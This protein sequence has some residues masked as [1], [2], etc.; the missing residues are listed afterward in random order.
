MDSR[1]GGRSSKIDIPMY[2]QKYPFI[3]NRG[4]S[5]NTNVHKWSAY[6][7]GTVI[8][9]DLLEANHVTA[10]STSGANDKSNCQMLCKTINRSKGNR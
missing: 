1:K 10:W 2:S 3:W 4:L 8:R 7:S 6:I 9:Q 5:I